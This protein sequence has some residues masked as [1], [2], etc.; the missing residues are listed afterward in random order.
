MH[1]S[2]QAKVYSCTVQFIILDEGE[3]I[4]RGGGGGEVHATLHTPGTETC[5]TV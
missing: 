5:S 4:V 1:F 2:L 3:L